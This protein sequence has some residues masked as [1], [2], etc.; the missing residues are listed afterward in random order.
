VATERI[1]RRLAA[2]LAA[3]VAGYSRLMGADEIGTLAALK[4]LRRK[5]FDPAISEHHGR[6][7]KTTGDGILVEFASAVDAVNCAMGVQ[8]RMAKPN[9]NTTSQIIFR[10]GIN[11]GDIIIDGDDIIGDGVN[12]AARIENECEPGSVCLSGS[13][14]EQVR[15]KTNFVFDDLG[16]R[17]LKNIERPVRLYA[18]RTAKAPSSSAKATTEVQKLLS[19]PDKP[20]IAVL[21]FE[22]MSTDLEQEFF[23]DGVVED[24]ITAL[25]RF[26]ALFVIARNT[27]FT[28]KRRAVNVKKVGRELG[29]RYV[30]EGSVRKSANRL[31]IS[32]QLIDAATGSHLW[33]DRFEGAI[34]DV[35]ELQDQVT[36]SVVGAIAPAIEKAEI[37]RAKRKPTDSLDAYNLYLRG[38]SKLYQ[39]DTKQS[40]EEALRLFKMAL[41]IDPDFASAYVGAASC[42]VSAK[43]YGWSAGT[44]HEIIEVRQLA[45]RGMSLG[46]EDASV[47]AFSAWALAY[48]TRDLRTGSGLIDRA[49]AMNSNLA[50]AWHYG[51]WIKNW[52]GEREVALE[53]FARAMRLSPLDQQIALMKAGTAHCLFF[54]GRYDEAASWA[55]LAFQEVAD[56]QAVL[57]ITAASNALTGRTAEAQEAVARLRQL[58]ATLRVSNLKDVLGPYG[59]EDITR[60]QEALRRAGLPE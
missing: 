24:I 8:E 46:K 36:E 20:S 33:A 60:Y 41:E 51:G 35:F 15:G 59:A 44:P 42:Y 38:L 57:R 31:R 45:Q 50:E 16:E 47:L 4:A 13:A 30:L 1:E 48:Y 40:V 9:K 52:L 25:S 28:Y 58:N 23:A 49:L 14:F 12:I 29:V 26:K 54:L 17:A 22:N 19:L 43:G 53:R 56:N 37:D 21:P 11:V 32:G 5:I 3:D 10:I 27:S 7:V 2:V 6:I 55:G 34:A 18:A 39:L